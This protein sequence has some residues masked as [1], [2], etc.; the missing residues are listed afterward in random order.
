MA[1]LLSW[2]TAM[3]TE[4]GG[5]NDALTQRKRVSQLGC[6]TF[7]PAASCAADECAAPKPWL[8]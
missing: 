8:L 7:K 1:Q 2:R 4:L 5:R 3:L 6:L